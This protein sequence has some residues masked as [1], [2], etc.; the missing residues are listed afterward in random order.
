LFVSATDSWWDRPRGSAS[1]ALQV[2]YAAEFGVSA[3]HC[4][5]GTHITAAQLGDPTAEVTAGQELALVTNLVRAVGDRSGLGLEAGLRYGLHVYGIFGFAVLSSATLR[6][7]IAVAERFR[8]LAY[9]LVDVHSEPVDGEVWIVLEGA[10]TPAAAR[11]YA[12]ERD[13]AA[14]TL[15]QRELF[16][17]PVPLARVTLEFPEPAEPAEVAAYE[18]AFGVRPQFGAPRNTLV[19]D[20]GLLDLALPRASEFAAAQC[21][22]QCQVLLDRRHQRLGVAGRV[23]SELLRDQREMAGEDQVA[24]ALNVGTRTLRRRLATEGTSFR[25]IVTETR[26]LLAQELLETGQLTI[27]QVADRLGYADASS[28]IHAFTRWSGD[29]PGRWVRNARR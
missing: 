23:R 21:Q 1:A 16:A 27:E 22:A 26:G 10:S 2:A 8:E 5:A 19:I 4:L 28:F 15:M 17:E 13:A 25:A 12:I 7:G 14:I 18:R 9:A 11:R 6:E 24:A 20:A 29:P 3:R